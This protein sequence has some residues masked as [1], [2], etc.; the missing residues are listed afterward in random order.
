MKAKAH[1]TVM[2]D[3]EGDAVSVVDAARD[4]SGVIA[5]HFNS[6]R[7]PGLTLGTVKIDTKTYCQALQVK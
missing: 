2:I 1:I 4:F 7:Y 5:D 3:I 6:A